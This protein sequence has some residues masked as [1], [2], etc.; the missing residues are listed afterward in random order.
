MRGLRQGVRHGGHQDLPKL[1]AESGRHGFRHGLRPLWLGTALSE[2]RGAHGPW[3]LRPAF[4]QP[5]G[6]G[7][8]CILRADSARG[9]PE[10]I[11]R[12][13]IRP[14][15]R[16]LRRGAS[17]IGSGNSAPVKRVAPGGSPKCPTARASS[18]MRYRR[19]SSA[20]GRTAR[21]KRDREESSEDLRSPVP[22][23]QGGIRWGGCHSGRHRASLR[24]IHPPQDA[25]ALERW[26]GRMTARS[27]HPWGGEEICT[28]LIALALAGTLAYSAFLGFGYHHQT[29]FPGERWRRSARNGAHFEGWNKRFIQPQYRKVAEF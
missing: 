17:E 6:P 18:W 24:V 16:I 29:P 26:T 2:L 21:L 23:V 1:P 19:G 11:I 5:R 14:F 13:A 25:P 15:R 22:R 20:S 7:N 9:T 10:T 27:T 28:S 3:P 4:P 12:I 8:P